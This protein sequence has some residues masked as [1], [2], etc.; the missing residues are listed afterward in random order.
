VLVFKPWE[1]YTRREFNTILKVL[2]F[3]SEEI[4]TPVPLNKIAPAEGSAPT[5]AT[6]EKPA[7]HAPA[8]QVTQEVAGGAVSVEDASEEPKM[9]NVDSGVA[10]SPARSRVAPRSDVDRGDLEEDDETWTNQPVGSSPDDGEMND[11]PDEGEDEEDD[12]API[13]TRKV[14]QNARDVICEELPARAQRAKLRLRPQLTGAFVIEIAN[15]GEKFLFDWRG[16]EAKVTPVS[17]PVDLAAADNTDPSKVDSIISISDQHMM[18]VR[19]GDLNPQVAMLADK[20]RVQGKIGP[21]VYLFNLVA[22][23]VRE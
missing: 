5:G 23:R 14:I 20:I 8:Q 15:T 19:S 18:A 6:S 1:R 22:P 11:G 3:M 17:G 4:D 2:L 9:L 13:A 12:D 10:K 21:A 7:S 16:E